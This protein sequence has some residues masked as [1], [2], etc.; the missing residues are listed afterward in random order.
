MSETRQTNNILDDIH[1]LIPDD[2]EA[3][4]LLMHASMHSEIPLISDISQYIADGGKRIRPIVA[5]LI[6]RA[7]GH[8]QRH[9]IDIA[10]IVEFIHTATLLHDDVVDHSELR[11]GKETANLVWGNEASVLVGDFLY[12]RAFQLLTL[13]NNNKLANILANAS[14]AMAESEVLQLMHR[15]NP[16]ISRQDYLKIITGKTA[17]LFEAASTMSANICECDPSVAEKMKTFGKHFGLVFQLVD[18]AL[19][20]SGSSKALGKNIGDDLME[21]KI[22]LPLIHA[23]DHGSDAQKNEIKEAI[24][25][26]KVKSFDSIKKAIDDTKAI[27]HTIDCAK[28]YAKIAIDALSCLSP[29]EYRDALIALTEFSIQRNN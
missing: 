23:L 24:Q 20:Y 13:M 8:D 14:S 16:A 6:A 17:T 1:R 2:I 5:L 21:G 29:S 26:G 27:E 15:H 22:T 7:L 19:D 12:A 28:Q 4:N 18:D 3:V 11:R 9:H 10:C 25:S